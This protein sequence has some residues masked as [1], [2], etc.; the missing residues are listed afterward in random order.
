MVEHS[1]GSLPPAKRRW[2]L[3]VWIVP[4]LLLALGLTAVL[5][6]PI[7][8]GAG[9]FRQLQG[10]Q[11]YGGD[12]ELV[13]SPGLFFGFVLVQNLAFG[14]VVLLRVFYFARLSPG[15]LG[16]VAA[17]PWRLI[18]Q[19]LASGAVFL[20]LNV[21][22]SAAFSAIGI[23]Q[24]QAA[25]Y[26]LRQG[27]LPG[28]LLIAIAGTLLAPLV[29]ELFFR[30]Y[31]YGALRDGLGIPAATGISAALFSLAHVL[32]ATQGLVAL[33]IPIF[34][35]GLLLAY[36]RERSGSLLPCIVAHMLNNT[37]GITVLLYCTNVPLAEFCPH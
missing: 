31:V 5:S 9:I 19:G 33:L 16:L 12:G 10:S 4:D 24:N 7:L 11:L 28:Q 6:L 29:E 26:P 30:G 13:M 2:P 8:I 22:L 3:M 15:W 32:S 37:L 21:A 27:D 35:L 18:G 36:I 14:I 23:E 1:E 34:L 17:Q 25:Q 20:V